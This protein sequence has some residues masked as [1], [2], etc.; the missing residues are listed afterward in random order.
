MRLRINENGFVASAEERPVTMVGSVE[1]L[2]IDPVNVTHHPG[3]ASP[4]GLQQEVVVGVHQTEGI[5]FCIPEL[6][7]LAEQR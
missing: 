4:R 5:D 6:T 2:G 1:A 7:G 3:Q